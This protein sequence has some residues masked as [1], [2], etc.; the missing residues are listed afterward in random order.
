M[1]KQG[2]YRDP[3][4]RSAQK[5]DWY[6]QNKDRLREKRQGRSTHR[7]EIV[8]WDT[9]SDPWQQGRDERDEEWVEFLCDAE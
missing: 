1:T 7:S 9:E 4:A 3:N 8:L 5:A 2:K 6:Q